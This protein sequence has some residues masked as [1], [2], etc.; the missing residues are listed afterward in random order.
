MKAKEVHKLSVEEL[1][2][3]IE[4]LRK[5]LFEV[6]TQAVTEKI[7]DTSQFSKIRR[8]IAQHLTELAGR[9]AS[10]GQAKAEKKTAKG[11]AQKRGSKKKSASRGRASGKSGAGRS[12]GKKTRSKTAASA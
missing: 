4:R 7:K 11:G 2:I 9:Q 10:N 3:E 8:D 1:N 5:R 6:R 12:T